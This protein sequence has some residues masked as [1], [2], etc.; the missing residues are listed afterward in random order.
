M[1]SFSGFGVGAVAGC[2][3]LA[4]S[5]SAGTVF[6]AS[7]ASPDTNAA[8]PGFNNSQ[9]TNNA[10]WFN[11]NGNPQGGF[12]VDTDS[13]IEL[14][15]RAKY[16]QDPNVIDSPT[17]LYQVNSGNQ[18]PGRA[19]WNYEYSVDLEPNG[20]GSLTFADVTASLMITDETTHHTATI[21]DLTS[22]APDN[23][24]FGSTSGDT[25]VH[26]TGNG[27][28]PTFGAD[29]SLENSENPE[30][31][32]FPLA[33]F[34]DS[35]APD[36]YEFVLTVTQNSTVLATDT[37]DVQVAPEPSTWL[38]LLTGLAGVAFYARRRQTV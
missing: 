30:Y 2:L 27:T 17:D 31:A 20:I 25:G 22:F 1:K 24:Y 14:G 5:A 33:A 11:G 19:L 18:V 6:D 37:I 15:L 9:P 23:S 38:M 7:L 10:S 36:L 8:T 16:R 29:W 35:S 4:G 26:Q 12:T 34:Y 21:A 3:L 28:P 13:G 32:S